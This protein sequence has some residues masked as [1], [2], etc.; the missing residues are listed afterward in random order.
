M[1]SLLTAFSLDWGA[2]VR[3][4]FATESAASGGVPALLGCIID[5][6][7]E[8]ALFLAAPLIIA[9]AV[10]SGIAVVCL[11]ARLRGQRCVVW[12]APP[13]EVF[14]NAL[15][16]LAF[17]LWPSLVGE[18]LRV[19]DCSVELD[20]ESYLSADV[21]V[22]CASA[23]YK[24]LAWAASAY[25]CTL[26]P[27]FPIG[28]FVLLHWN[29]DKLAELSEGADGTADEGARR[30]QQRYGFL[31]AGYSS[32][33]W[34]FE[35]RLRGRS[36]PVQLLLVACGQAGLFETRL[37]VWWECVV[38]LRKALLVA[39]TVL[40]A[41]SPSF[42]VY[43]GL[44]VLLVAFLLHV[45]CQ[46]YQNPAT[47]FLETLSL[48]ATLVSL[49]LGQALSL[50][51]LSESGELAVRWAAATLN[52]A[53]LVYFS[54]YGVSEMREARRVRIDIANTPNNLVFDDSGRV[55]HL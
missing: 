52:I 29:R 5:S 53:M 37:F 2:T 3:W 12:G 31:F 39:V 49:L 13:L 18:M 14:R 22:N 10:G 28:L 50:D 46:P 47:G 19:L 33:L 7:T 32:R 26:L 40:F 30:F 54:R 55:A 45:L 21:S 48:G 1:T 44:W 34:K 25:L 17:L 43:A 27:A 20:G 6:S 16:A 38:M 8:T 36:A 15:L 9:V 4:L 11:V 35:P 24:T 41:R 23:G 51:G 42:Q